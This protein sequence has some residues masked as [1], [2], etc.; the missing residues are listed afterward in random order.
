VRLPRSRHEAETV[1]R[2]VDAL[3]SGDV[4]RVVALLTD[5][6]RVTMPPEPFEMRGARPVADY[7]CR[8][9][10][11]GVK[12]VPTRANDAP[13]FAY[14]RRDPHADVYR[15]S[16]IMVASVVGSRVSSLA[17]F[18]DMS[19]FATFGLPRTIQVDPGA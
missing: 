10:G 17:K 19:L 12:V 7:L 5:D 11:E 18:G 3:E 13:A 2:F 15:A 8:V 1:D 9:W 14:Y 16:A 6:A 4:K